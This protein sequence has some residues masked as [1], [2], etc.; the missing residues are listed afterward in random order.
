MSGSDVKSFTDRFV[1]LA[2]NG[3]LAYRTKLIL[4]VVPREIVSNLLTHAERVMS[5]VFIVTNRLLCHFVE[6]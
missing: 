2:V 5:F 6:I 4:V 1:N 3:P